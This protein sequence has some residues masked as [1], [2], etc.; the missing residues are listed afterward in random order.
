MSGFS[1]ATIKGSGAVIGI[2]IAILIMVQVSLSLIRIENQS[3]EAGL[4]TARDAVYSAALQCY[5]L[6]GSYPADIGYL[7]DNYG[8][9]LQENRYVYFYQSLGGNLTPVIEVVPK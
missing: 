5:A 2:I 4:D 7:V 9:Q 8:L 6:E 3:R 1:R